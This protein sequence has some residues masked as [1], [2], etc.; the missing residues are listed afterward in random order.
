MIHYTS[1]GL[2]GFVLLDA[3]MSGALAF[4]LGFLFCVWREKEITE[5]YFV[6]SGRPPRLCLG[7]VA[8][9]N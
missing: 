2:E 9:L 6:I 7:G 1:E 5:L 4:V 8:V 3:R